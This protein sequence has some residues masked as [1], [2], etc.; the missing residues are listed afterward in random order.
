MWE[1]NS[2][3]VFQQKVHLFKLLGYKSYNEML[4]V[5]SNAKNNT[6][7][8]TPFSK[9]C[10]RLDPQKCMSLNLLGMKIVH[11]HQD[12]DFVFFY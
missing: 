2:I 11:K 3:L 4:L 12:L 8:L 7:K 10:E 6:F 5:L 1:I 9:K